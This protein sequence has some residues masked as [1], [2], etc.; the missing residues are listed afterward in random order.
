MDNNLYILRGA[1]NRH[2][3]EYFISGGS[4]VVTDKA[5]NAAAF[6]SYN[7]AL[8]AAEY[9]CNNGAVYLPIVSLDDWS[10]NKMHDQLYVLECVGHR[11]APFYYTCSTPDNVQT[12]MDINDA[13]HFTSEQAAL[14]VQIFLEKQRAKFGPD[15]M[16]EFKIVPHMFW[17]DQ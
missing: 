6:I 17:T 15:V 9:L 16:P 12:S 10:E 1:A 8:N 7:A 3:N 4:W 14:G 5:R 13:A 2:A 11:G